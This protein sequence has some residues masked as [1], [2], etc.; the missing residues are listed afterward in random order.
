MSKHSK[1]QSLTEQLD[2]LSDL[3]EECKPQLEE[4]FHKAEKEVKKAMDEKPLMTLGI[5]ALI[6]LVLG[7]LIGKSGRR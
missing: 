4:A 3:I 1:D 7:F 5:T 2:Q 6:F